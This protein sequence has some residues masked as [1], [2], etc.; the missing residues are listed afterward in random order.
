MKMIP[1]NAT[2]REKSGKGPSKQT[3]RQGLIPGIVY[4]PGQ[5]PLLVTFPEREFSTVIHGAQGEHA[6]VD[7]KIAD[8]PKLGGPAMLK[9]VQH[10]P[11]RGHVIHADLMRID[12]TRKI[13]TMV[14]TKLE[15]RPIGVVDG[16]ILEHAAREVEVTCLPTQIPDFLRAD[17]SEIKIAHSI[18][19]AALSIPDG[20]ELVTNRDRVLATVLIPRLV[21]ETVAAAPV[22][23]A[24]PGAVPAEGAEGAA[25]AAPAAGAAAPGAAGAA[26]AAK[27]APA[28]GK[29]APA[30]GKGAPPAGGRKS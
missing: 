24:E 7:L 25:A 8:Q 19:V 4:G 22:E 11:V 15:G 13:T 9:E 26:P 2:Q 28:A 3:R 18:S 5:Q 10:H 27:G 23:G 6:I 16:G 30:G 29:A 21:V 17:V 20:V 12:L 1:L 14:P